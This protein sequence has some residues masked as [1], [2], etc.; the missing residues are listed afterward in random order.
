[1]VQHDLSPF[2]VQGKVSL[3]EVALGRTPL[4]FLEKHTSVVGRVSLNQRGFR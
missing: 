2:Q 4:S 1:M 3:G